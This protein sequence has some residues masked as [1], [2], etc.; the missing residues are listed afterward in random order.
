MA[1]GDI[2]A[3]LEVNSTYV[4]YVAELN[5][6][7]AVQRPEGVIRAGSIDIDTGDEAL[8]S[9]LVQNTG[10]AALPAGFLT[11]TADIDGDEDFELAPASV[12]LVINGQ[13]ITE[14]GT[15][16]GLAARDLLVTV[17]SRS[18]IAGS[19]INGCAL[20]GACAAEPPPQQPPVIDTPHRTDIQLTGYDGLGDG[21]FG[22]E[23]DIDDGESG[24]DRSS[25][26]SPP[27][28]LF[29]SRPLNES[30][31]STIPSLVPA[32]RRSTAPSWM[33][34]R[35]GRGRE[36]EA[37]GQGQAGRRQV[38]RSTSITARVLLLCIDFAVGARDRRKRAADRQ[39]H[40]LSPGDAGVMCTAQSPRHR[41][42]AHGAVRS[43]LRADL[44]GCLERGRKLAAV[45]GRSI[46]LG[47]RA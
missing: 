23:G 2:L 40:Q 30:G 37:K 16:T 20:V 27:N 29:D 1:S 25:P 39:S 44:P 47:S 21:L 26:I 34:R 5:A 4:G 36:E 17:R 31:T 15:V 43:C 22:N 24:D 41:R 12:N 38:T 45:G 11:T 6:P 35:R 46:P 3:K 19:T 7:A 42:P 18:F 14:G 28:P 33:T 10:T 9:L 8:Q 32:I 13:L